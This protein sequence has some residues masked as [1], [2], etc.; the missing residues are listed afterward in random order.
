MKVR[1]TISYIIPEGKT[2]EVVHK[3]LAALKELA[4]IVGEARVDVSEDE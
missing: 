3:T 2:E 4:P 1:L